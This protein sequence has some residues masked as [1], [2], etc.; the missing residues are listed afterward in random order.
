MRRGILKG[1][2]AAC[3]LA[4]AGC[5][6]DT[7]QV[8]YEVPD[9][10]VLS[11]Q[12]NRVAMFTIDEPDVYDVRIYNYPGPDTPGITLP[13]RIV[14]TTVTAAGRAADT[15]GRTLALSQAI[16]EWN[17]NI[18][19]TLT[20][21]VKERIEAHGYTVEEVHTDNHRHTSAYR[22]HKYLGTYPTT[23]QPVDAF[24]HVYIEFA[25]YTAPTPTEPYTP[26][27]EVFM[28]VVDPDSKDR[29]YATSLVY[30]GPVPVSD[31]NNMP[32][33]PQFTVRDFEWLCAGPN[34]CEE[35]PAVKGLRAASKGIAE[36]VE[37]HLFAKKG[38]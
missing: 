30:G 18:G 4:L 3:A 29:V 24:L 8:S 10:K 16:N 36:L 38:S 19:R 25:G 9:Q 35:N 28:D 6:S 5:A 27:L 2:I 34:A 11:G 13:G 15:A 20:N 7:P 14:G 26:T 32:A 21:D 23:S 37:R 1:T 22:N 33:D 17:F 31:A 12:H